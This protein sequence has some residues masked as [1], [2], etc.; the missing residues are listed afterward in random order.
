VIWSIWWKCNKWTHDCPHVQ[1]IFSV[2]KNGWWGNKNHI[3]QMLLFLNTRINNKWSIA[4]F[5]KSFAV[6][7]T[8]A[9]PSIMERRSWSLFLTISSIISFIVI[10]TVWTVQFSLD[11]FFLWITHHNVTIT[12]R[13]NII[14]LCKEIVI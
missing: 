10:L 1:H 7:S 14:V 12:V 8:S 6:C 3:E 13:H 11:F 4:Q 9:D 5:V 2:K